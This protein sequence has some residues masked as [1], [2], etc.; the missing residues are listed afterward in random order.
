MCVGFDERLV[1]SEAVCN[2]VCGCMFLTRRQACFE[3]SSNP[4]RGERGAALLMHACTKVVGWLVC[5]VLCNAR[6][7]WEA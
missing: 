5:V 4:V 6:A 2:P 3:T 1:G 7:T